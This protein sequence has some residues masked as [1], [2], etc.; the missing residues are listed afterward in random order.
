MANRVRRDSHEPSD[1]LVR[2]SGCNKHGDG[3][4]AVCQQ[5]HERK[6]FFSTF[7]SHLAP[8]LLSC[9]P[10]AQKLHLSATLGNPALAAHFRLA[11]WRPGPPSIVQLL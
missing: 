2:E 7:G 6:F 5:N 10:C 3:E 8:S 1:F 11:G 4:L 9:K